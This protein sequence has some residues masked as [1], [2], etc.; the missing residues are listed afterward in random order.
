MALTAAE[1]ASPLARRP[2]DLRH[3]C[4]STWLNGGV[5]P[6]QV[7]EWGDLHLAAHGC[8]QPAGRQD[9]EGRKFLQ[10]TGPYLR[11]QRVGRLGLEPRTGGL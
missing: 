4:L 10:V 2:Y 7:A 8:P 9:H 6:T 3:A 1:Q 5:Y 11:F